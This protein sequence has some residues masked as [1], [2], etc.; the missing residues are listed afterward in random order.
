MLGWVIAAALAQDADSPYC[1]RGIGAA[2]G[3]TLAHRDYDLTTPGT[4]AWSGSPAFTQGCLRLFDGEGNSDPGLWMGLDLV[5]TLVHSYNRLGERSP[6]WVQGNFGYGRQW[7]QHLV[8]VQLSTNL[9]TVGLGVRW[10]FR[11]A[12]AARR[13]APALNVTITAW[14]AL[15]PEV[16]ATVSVDFSKT[17][18]ADAVD[19]PT[20]PVQPRMGF[21]AGTMMGARAELRFEAPVHGTL[22]V[23][24]GSLTSFSR[25]ALLQPTALAQIT[26]AEGDVA[27]RVGPGATVG[28]T[29]HSNQ[30]IPV[31][32]PSVELGGASRVRVH[33][34]VV[35]GPATETT[36]V[37]W[38]PDTS[39]I[40]VW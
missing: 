8:G 21:E 33:L 30:W 12:R 20:P 26:V 5:P 37:Y 9:V 1:L 15:D 25:D 19:A 34:G 6:V 24:L 18:L 13:A 14:P 23:R 4:V 32:G 40:L 22:G 29:R 35:L 11:A 16:R 10:R 27:A 2:A 28:V 17:P 39:M 36:A 3:V 31:A 7:G 38:A